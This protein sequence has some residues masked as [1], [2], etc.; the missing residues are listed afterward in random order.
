MDGIVRHI[1]AKAGQS[2]YGRYVVL[3]HPGATPAFYSLYAH[4][5]AIRPGLKVGDTLK[6]GEQLGTMG[7]SA[8]GYTIPKARAHLHFE[9]GLAATETFQ[10]WYDRQKFGS[11]NYHGRWN[12]MN[13]MG[14][15][16]RG[17][18]DAFR[19]KQV[20]D[21]GEYL[22]T[23]P[24]AVTVRVASTRAPDYAE[25][26]PALVK[27]ELVPGALLG[28]WEIDCYWTGLP[29]ALRPLSVSDVAGQRPNSVQIVAV[30]QEERVAHR[31][32]TLVRGR[33]ATPAP[34]KDL[35]DVLEK[36]FG[37]LR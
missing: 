8:G 37:P 20:N 12:G 4:L 30:D 16:P 33:G 5:G 24:V 11:P 34:A 7:Y 2:S 17:F 1:A 15:D 26:Y 14:F 31:A 29:L 27:A 28:G 25:R 9:M 10:P 23:L 13:L 3:E 21:I 32:I 36:L 19:A 6:R 22:A 35:L 18:F